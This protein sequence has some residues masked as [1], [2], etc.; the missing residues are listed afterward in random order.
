MKHIY[1]NKSKVVTIEEFLEVMESTRMK[2]ENRTR[3]FNDNYKNYYWSRLKYLNDEFKNQYL[4]QA[5]LSQN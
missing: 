5:S 2:A 3:T 1:K 4:F